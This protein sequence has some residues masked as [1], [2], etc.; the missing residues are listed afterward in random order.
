MVARH[1]AANRTSAHRR[2]RLR[3]QR[4]SASPVTAAARL[5]HTVKSMLA[6]TFGDDAA[7]LKALN[8][9]RAIHQRVNG[10]L[11]EAVGPFA[12]GTRYSAEDSALVLWVHATLLDSI[13]LVFELLVGP[14]SDVEHDAVLRGG[15]S[16]CGRSWRTRRRSAPIAPGASRLSG[17][18]VPVWCDYGRPAGARPGPCRHGAAGCNARGAFCVDEPSP[19]RRSV[20][21]RRARSVRIHV[22]PAT[23]EGAFGRSQEPAAHAAGPSR[24]PGAVARRSF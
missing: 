21:G 4:L 16:S 6:L 2:R 1:P 7:R 14:L 8:G 23:G 18:D 19:H 22:E 9:I 15:S 3:A 10:R 24:S 5:H 17:R 20:A 11:S 12:V 13:P